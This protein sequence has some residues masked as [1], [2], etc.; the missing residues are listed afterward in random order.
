MQC[1]FGDGDSPDPGGDQTPTLPNPGAS[2]SPQE[3]E[4]PAQSSTGSNSTDGPRDNIPCLQYA[5]SCSL[6]FAEKSKGISCLLSCKL[7]LS[8]W[9]CRPSTASSQKLKNFHICPAGENDP[10]LY[11]NIKKWGECF[12]S[13]RLE[14]GITVIKNDD[15]VS[16]VSPKGDYS[17]QYEVQLAVSSCCVFDAGCGAPRWSSLRATRW[18]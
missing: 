17:F 11:K 15:I 7:Y 2:S 18:S 9:C 4:P 8:K 12:D 16:V 6:I 3:S 5:Q 1:E 13:K 10:P 14:R